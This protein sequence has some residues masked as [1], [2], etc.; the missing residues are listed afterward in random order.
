MV[1]Y[2]IGEKLAQETFPENNNERLHAWL[3]CL[4]LGSSYKALIIIFRVHLRRLCDRIDA[5]VAIFL[6]KWLWQH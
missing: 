1:M 4:V 3:I 5:S 2:F 6:E